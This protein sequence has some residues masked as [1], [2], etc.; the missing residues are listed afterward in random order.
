M[1]HPVR[2]SRISIKSTPELYP[3]HLKV[4]SH[5]RQTQRSGKSLNNRSLGLEWLLGKSK[6]LDKNVKTGILCQSM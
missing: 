1:S 2:W 5:Y 4:G 6:P 3:H